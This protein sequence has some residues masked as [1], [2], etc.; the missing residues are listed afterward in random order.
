MRIRQAA[1]LTDSLIRP[2]NLRENIGSF[3]NVAAFMRRRWLVPQQLHVNML[4]MMRGEEYLYALNILFDI[5]INDIT[6]LA[7]GL[8]FHMLLGMYCVYNII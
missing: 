2:K 6:L 5:I 4:K 3:K 7:I 1:Y 8:S